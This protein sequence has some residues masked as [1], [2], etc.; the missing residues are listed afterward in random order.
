MEFAPYNVLYYFAV[1]WG[2]APAVRKT[3]YG[4]SKLPP[5]NHIVNIN[6]SNQPITL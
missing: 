1:G 2:L 5:Y 4:G 3:K 6:N